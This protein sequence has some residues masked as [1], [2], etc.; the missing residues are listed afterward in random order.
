MASSIN[1]KPQD[2]TNL[3]SNMRSWL[4]NINS[5]Q[6][7]MVSRVRSLESSWNDPQYHMFLD[8]LAALSSQLKSNTESLEG[9]SKSLQLMARNMEDQARLFQRNMQNLKR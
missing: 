8:Q 9:M 7:Q 1:I 4:S 6:T 5:I 2:L 3:A